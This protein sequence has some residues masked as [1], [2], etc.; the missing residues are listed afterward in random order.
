[1]LTPTGGRRAGLWASSRR[2]PAEAL[3]LRASTYARTL[4]PARYVTVCDDTV[5]AAV[6]KGIAMPRASGV[7][8]SPPVLLMTKAGHGQHMPA[9]GSRVAM[10]GGRRYR[11]SCPR[12]SGCYEKNQG[13]SQRG[14]LR[15]L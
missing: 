5:E 14:L 10:A 1:M 8:H 3:L 7:S 4:R 9:R 6:A 12:Q 13:V 11:A 2:W 15:K